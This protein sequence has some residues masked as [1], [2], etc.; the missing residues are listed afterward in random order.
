MHYLY[1]ERAL[2]AVRSET[3]GLP[4]IDNV[5]EVVQV[6]NSLG[7]DAAKVADL[8]PDKV[9]VLDDRV[10]PLAK[11]VCVVENQD[12]NAAVEHLSLVDEASRLQH[13]GNATRPADHGLVIELMLMSL[14]VDG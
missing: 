4:V 5:P 6:G 14:N 10:L 11:S 8:L 1:L 12:V 13:A 2:D 9:N 7:E 3:T